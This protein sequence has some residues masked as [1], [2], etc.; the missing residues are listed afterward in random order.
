MF[1][2]DIEDFVVDLARKRNTATVHNPYLGPDA[3]ENLRLYLLAM[4]KLKGKRILLVGE[5]PGYKGCGITGIPFSSGRVFE[6]FDHPLLNEIGGQIRLGRIESE[7]TAT[8]VWEYLSE[9]NSTPLFWN[10]FPFHPHVRGNRKSNRAPTSAEVDVGIGYLKKLAAIFRPGTVGGVG[11]KGV[12]CARKAFPNRQIVAIRH[13]SF[14]GKS[15]FIAG[16]DKIL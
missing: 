12:E 6:R 2:S 7:N 15:E 16:M 5:A 10:S 4:R 11:R 1:M 9:K 14:G 8:I 13:P 3:A